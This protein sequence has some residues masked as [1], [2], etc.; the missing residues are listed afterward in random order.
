MMTTQDLEQVIRDCL[1]TIYKA[2]YIGK[3]EVKKM[4]NGYLIN[5]GLGTPDA[6]ISLY[7]ELEGKEL[8]KFLM[9]EFRDRRINPY[10]FGYIQLTYPVSCNNINRKCCDTR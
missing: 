7:I 9:K 8:I 10:N 2:D 5:L 4:L 6:P 1:K 3:L